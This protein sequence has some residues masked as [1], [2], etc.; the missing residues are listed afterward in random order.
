MS[1]RS[2][3]V[4]P[5]CGYQFE[6]TVELDEH[7]PCPE[8]GDERSGAK[9]PAQPLPGHRLAQIEAE[10]EAYVDGLTA[11]MYNVRARSR[12]EM[13]DERWARVKALFPGSVRIC[14]EDVLRLHSADITAY[15][16][17]LTQIL[18]TAKENT[19]C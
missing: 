2:D 11:T 7:A 18:T 6:T 17:T 16:A 15:R 1:R 13:T 4:C 3:L 8:A 9:H 10:V 12:Q 19:P 14:R 5:I